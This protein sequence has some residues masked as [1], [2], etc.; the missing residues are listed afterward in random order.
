MD[1]WWLAA[2]AGTAQKEPSGALW[3]QGDPVC[4][5]APALF[6]HMP[7][8]DHLPYVSLSV[9]QFRDG[10]G[11]RQQYLLTPLQ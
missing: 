9:S 11:G 1:P 8:A 4:F 2:E 5:S 7:M 3:R 6:S 10:G